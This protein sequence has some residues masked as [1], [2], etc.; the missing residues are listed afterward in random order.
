LSVSTKLRRWILVAVAC[1]P[2]RLSAQAGLEQATYDSLAP[3]GI[4]FDLGALAGHDFYGTGVAGVR[5]DAGF[6]APRLR[7]LVGLSYAKSA[8]SGATIDRF[9]RQLLSLVQD[10]DSNATIDVGAITLADL[11][12][13]VDLQYMFPQGKRFWTYLGL[14]AGVHFRNGSG[15]GINGTFV[16]DA[17]D[18]PAPALNASLGLEYMLT[19]P[20]RLTLDAR[21]MLLSQF[22]TASLRVGFMYRF[23]GAR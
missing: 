9:N 6:L 12:A 1:C 13:D 10:P 22:S 17:L 14:G 3:S 8:F 7:V 16:E 11:T 20:W 18:G 2:A 5:F 4:Q 23:P 19:P 15:Q 21:G